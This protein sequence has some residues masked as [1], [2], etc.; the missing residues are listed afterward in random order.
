MLPPVRSPWTISQ[1][2]HSAAHVFIDVKGVIKESED[3]GRNDL[4]KRNLKSLALNDKRRNSHLKLMTR[5]PWTITEISYF[6]KCYSVI[7]NVFSSKRSMILFELL[8][9][10]STF[11]TQKNISGHNKNRAAFSRRVEHIPRNRKRCYPILLVAKVGS[12]RRC[13]HSALKIIPLVEW[14]KKNRVISASVIH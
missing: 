14:W 9:A 7:S 11:A 8:Q 2:R 12:S 10:F 13:L 4:R 3:R 6:F 1:A 5:K